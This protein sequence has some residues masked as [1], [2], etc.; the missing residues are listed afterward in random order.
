MKPV[1]AETVYARFV[2]IS[3]SEIFIIIISFQLTCAFH[4]VIIPM[5]EIALATALSVV[6]IFGIRIFPFS[7]RLAK[8][9][10]GIISGNALLF[11]GS[12]FKEGH[13]TSDGETALRRKE[14][15]LKETKAAK[16]PDSITGLLDA[17]ERGRRQSDPETKDKHDKDTS[18][19]TD[20]VSVHAD[21]NANG[22]DDAALK[23]GRA[24]LRRLNV[25]EDSDASELV[26]SIIGYWENEPSAR[27]V[28]ES[29][30]ERR[31]MQQAQG[32][33]SIPLPR[34]IRADISEAP[35]ADYENMSSEQF[36]KLK[37]QLQRAALS[38]RR[39]R[40]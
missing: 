12:L 37:K 19:N 18:G 7:G 4:Y 14:N 29:M 26:E 1:N 8:E 20:T 36:R 34:P 5:M 31:G 33:R 15:I 21:D 2:I 35:E 38:G 22:Y 11:L 6:P 10:F 3:Y 28:R 24:M 23:L 16:K 39:I 40:I 32:S 9:C 30:K 17:F 27:S 13:R 25:S